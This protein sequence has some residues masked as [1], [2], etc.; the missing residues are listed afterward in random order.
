MSRQV[1]IAT[2]AVLTVVDAAIHFRRSL[3]PRPNPFESS[4]HE[5]FLLYAT[6]ALALAVLLIG[7]AKW[8][9]G[10]AWLISLA[11]IIWEI[12]AIAVWLVA[13]HA[14]NPPGIL[15]DEG[16]VSKVIEAVVILALLPTLREP[17]PAPPLGGSAG[18]Q[19][20]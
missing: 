13:Y 14:P 3:V 5:Q 16:Y 10:R 7:A 12:G 11:L 15:P 19:T 6:V 9:G 8:F 4:L 2:A 20:A 17:A 1:L 18:R